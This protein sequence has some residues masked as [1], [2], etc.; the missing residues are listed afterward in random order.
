[1]EFANAAL[2][3]EGGG[4]RGVYTSGVLRLLMDRGIWLSPVIGVSMGACNGANYVA[5][6]PERNRVVNIRFVDEF[7][8]L[9]YLRLMAGG[10]LF[11]MDFIF[12]DI[13]RRLVPFDFAAFAGNAAGFWIT[14]TDCLSGEAVHYE[15]GEFGDD[16][17]TLLRAS[18]S[19]PLVA[20]PVHFRGRMLMDGGI[21]DPVPVAKSLADG[22]ARNVIVLTRPRGYRKTPS[23]LA[24]LVRLRH[25]GLA[26]LHRA[27]AGRHLRYNRTMELIDDLEAA[28][29]A[30]V[31][32][33]QARL[34]VGRAERDKERLYA[35]YDQGYADALALQDDLR[36]YLSANLP[37]MASQM[38]ASRRT[39]S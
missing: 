28:G 31:I 36:A 4:L 26:G 13:P 37:S 38:S 11:G 22:N 17:L 21:S 8:Y 25:P 12:E 9:S 33:P 23:R 35:A 32:R 7:R 24:A 14:A 34:A 10:E 30:F 16:V 3:L 20:R 18:C 27:V 6:Q 39:P 1:M 5:R 19:L 2:I 29:R 15:K